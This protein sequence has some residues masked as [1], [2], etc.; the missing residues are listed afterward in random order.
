MTEQ[1]SHRLVSLWLNRYFLVILF[2][3]G[4]VLFLILAFPLRVYVDTG[5]YLETARKILSGQLPY[6]NYEEIN[7]PTIHYLNIL[8]ILLGRWMSINQ[9]TAYL[10]L[11]WLQLAFSCFAVIWIL[12]C[13]TGYSR[14]ANIYII[15]FVLIIQAIGSLILVSYGQREHLILLMFVPWFVLRWHRWNGGQINP[16]LAFI[17]GFSA[18]MGASIKPYFIPLFVVGDCYWLITNRNLRSLRQP[19]VFG[20]LVFALIYGVYFGI[21]EPQILITYFTHTV[22]D[23][24]RGYGAWGSVTVGQLLAADG[25]IPLIV[26]LLPWLI[27]PDQQDQT[28]SMARPLSLALIAALAGHVLQRNDYPYHRIP[29]EGLWYILLGLLIYHLVSVAAVRLGKKQNLVW[30]KFRLLSHLPLFIIVV[31]F[32]DWIY[33]SSQLMG[34]RSLINTTFNEL[35]VT[36]STPDDLIM[37]VDTEGGPGYPGLEQVNRGQASRYLFPYPLAYNFCGHEP[38]EPFKVDSPVPEAVNKYVA[39]FVEDVNRFKPPLIFIRLEQLYVCPYGFHLNDF[40]LARSTI[41]STINASYNILGDFGGQ[42]VYLRKN[43]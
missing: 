40:L 7:L 23:A 24:V 32:V 19:E 15:P 27:R 6:I 35:V 26:A 21:L 38:P 20:A 11:V 9:I 10:L 5:V 33:I 14:K 12:N 37:V 36:H 41:A 28:W 18:C 29:M 17:I 25:T 42:R 43:G 31:L 39:D 4:A 3:L 8:P 22:P 1:H 13:H 30:R 2:A 16:V 34:A